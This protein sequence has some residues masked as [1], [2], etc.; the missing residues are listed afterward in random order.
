MDINS[1]D[2]THTITAKEKEQKKNPLNTVTSEHITQTI[3][4]TN[5]S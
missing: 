3:Q 4:S 1:Q 2:K 5:R